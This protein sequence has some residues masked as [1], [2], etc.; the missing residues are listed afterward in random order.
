MKFNN[1][2]MFFTKGTGD[3]FRDFGVYVDPFK[4]DRSNSKL[5]TKKS[6]QSFF[7]DMPQRDQRIPNPRFVFFLM[8][9][10]H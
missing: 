2:M 10:L 8:S 3:E 6:S 4:R 7:I 9:S 5:L 1:Q